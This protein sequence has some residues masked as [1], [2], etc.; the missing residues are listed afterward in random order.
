M[1]LHLLVF[2]SCVDALF[3]FLSLSRDTNFLVPILLVLSN[4]K[5]NGVAPRNR[6]SSNGSID[7]KA[8]SF[9]DFPPPRTKK[10]NVVDRTSEEIEGIATMLQETTLNN[11]AYFGASAAMVTNTFDD[12]DLWGPQLGV[13]NTAGDVLVPEELQILPDPATREQLA[14]LYYKV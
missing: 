11:V 9:L 12:E 6:H 3:F 13:S 8:G 7:I 10:V 4:A 1:G 14:E 5:A 2:V